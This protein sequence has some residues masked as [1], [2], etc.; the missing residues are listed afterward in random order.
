MIMAA[1]LAAAFLLPLAYAI[2]KPLEL[3]RKRIPETRLR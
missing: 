1:V 3:K 2:G